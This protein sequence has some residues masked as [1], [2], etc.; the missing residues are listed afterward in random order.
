MVGIY[1][2]A[3]AIAEGV[4]I[5]AG[6]FATVQYSKISNSKNDE[7][8]KILTL[9]ITKIVF[10]MTFVAVITLLLLPQELF[11][12]MFGKDFGELKNV[13]PYFAPGILLL[14]FT[15]TISH[16]YSG[17][18]KPKMGLLGS[19]AGFIVTAIAGIILIP[20][21]DL[22]GAALTATLSYITS[23]LL[24]LLI[25]MKQ[26][27]LSFVDFMPDRTSFNFLKTWRT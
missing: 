22:K 15:I 19:A 8:N 10:L 4:W 20:R 23:S 1:S 24:L 25:F 7:E 26:K 18:G 27:K 16:Y 12:W 6:S 2:T 13:F 17:S 3:N 21:Y 9:Q 11:I 14:I 5:I